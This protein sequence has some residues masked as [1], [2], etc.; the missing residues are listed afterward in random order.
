MVWKFYDPTV[1]VYSDGGTDPRGH[2]DTYIFRRAE[3]MMLLAEAYVKN[4]QGTL[5]T[6]LINELR[7]RAG[8]SGGDLL[9]G[10]ATMD[11]VLDESA[12]ELFGESNR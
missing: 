1:I 11:D 9:S 12:R 7:Q 3:T 4:G 10:A 5:A 8:L 2:R 6:G